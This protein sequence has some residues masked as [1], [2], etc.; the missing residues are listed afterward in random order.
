MID[1]ERMDVATAREKLGLTQFQLAAV[2]GYGS[3]VRISEIE[4]GKRSL[5]A[6]AERLLTAYLDGYRPSDWPA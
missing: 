5:G 1:A 6:A 3:A 2:M 4:R